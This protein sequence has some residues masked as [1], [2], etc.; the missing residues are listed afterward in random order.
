MENMA[1]NPLGPIA[2]SK[3]DFERMLNLNAQR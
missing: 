3:K 2:N 1:L